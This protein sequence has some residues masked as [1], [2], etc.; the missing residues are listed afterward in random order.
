MR[1]DERPLRR[2]N[3][4]GAVRFVARYTS[5]DGKRRVAGT[6]EKKG[7]CKAPARGCCAQ[8]AIWAAYEVEMLG[9][10]KRPDTVGSYFEGWLRAH[11]R[12]ART[13]AGYAGRIR[14][15]LDVKLDG[16]PF[17]HWPLAKLR[18]KQIA[19]LVDVML[20]E[21]GRAASGT[22]AVVSVLSTMF[23]DAITDDVMDDN[24]ALGVR[25]SDKDPRVRKPRRK[26]ILASWEEMHN[27][28][29]AAGEYEAMVRVLSDC[30]LRLGEMLALERCH[31]CRDT[32]LV[33]NNAWHGR[34]SEGTKQGDSRT[35]PIPPG[36]RA[37]LD[38]YATPL[39]GPLF[40]APNGRVWHERSFYRVVWY[41]AQERSGLMLHPHDMRHSW[42]S[43][44][45]AAGAD[46]ADLALAAGQ[47]VATAT[48]I[49]THSTGGTFDLMRRAVG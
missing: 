21:H 40:P 3:P 29:R 19:G 48:S 18:R 26:R 17:R 5:S 35:V 44:L 10:A 31:D 15:V 1:R 8:H 2:V 24:P 20:R 14:A 11:P 6:F 32:L 49:Y 46:P 16:I 47:T 36:L 42:V 37:V 28:A 39:R 34:P 30:G 12:P 22:R 4:G 13:E 41:P 23:E 38:A 7:P 33:E 9:E 25:I 27:F 43:H 45:R